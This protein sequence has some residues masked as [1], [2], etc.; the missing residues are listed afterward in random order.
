M[1]A[2][3][4][5]CLYVRIICTN[6]GVLLKLVSYGDIQPVFL[7]LAHPPLTVCWPRTDLSAAPSSTPFFPVEGWSGL[8]ENKA[9]VTHLNHRYTLLFMH[10]Q[11]FINKDSNKHIL[12]IVAS[13][14]TKQ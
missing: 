13:S 8:R 4:W 11:Q 7:F 9:V 6:K 14:E 1:R 10:E 12:K 2:E 3:Y 5:L